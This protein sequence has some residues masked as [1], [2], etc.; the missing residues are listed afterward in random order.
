M[1]FR[2]FLGAILFLLA[3]NCFFIPVS[4]LKLDYYGIQSTIQNDRS[5][6]NVI[7][8]TLNES[9]PDFEYRLKYRISDFGVESEN[10]PI[11][12]ETR[13]TD[14]SVISCVL[15]DYADYD[16][17]NIKMEFKTW[18]HVR[19]VDENYDFSHF[20]PIEWEVERFFNII[21]LPQTATLASEIQNESFSP[22][23]GELLSD[24]K[25][26]M[27]YWNREGLEEGDDIYFSISY[28]MPIDATWDIGLMVV[29]AVIIIVSLGMF[30]M[31]NTYR[32]RSVKVIMPLLKGDEKVVVEILNKHGGSANQRVIVRE[33]DFSKA[34]VSRLVAN[35]KERGIVN[36]EIMGRTNKVSLKLRG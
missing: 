27:V 33:S 17:L 14:T 36:V 8:L 26:I 23:G 24:G 4:A 6:K 1:N 18:D 32:H 19:T 22:S 13:I 5:V 30:Y 12:C 21:Y 7:T 2:I 34:K 16:R 10:A 20:V 11:T 25:H 15:P 31:K 28:R 9:V 3:L 35:L 29:I